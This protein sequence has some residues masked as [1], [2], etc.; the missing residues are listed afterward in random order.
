MGKE[1]VFH[2]KRKRVSNTTV[3]MQL[4]NLT[5]VFV[6]ASAPCAMF[7]QKNKAHTQNFRG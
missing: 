4:K 5:L 1:N 7:H 3:V 6:T 2:G